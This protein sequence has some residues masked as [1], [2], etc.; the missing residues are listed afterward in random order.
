MLSKIHAISIVHCSYFDFKDT[1]HYLLPRLKV[2][3]CCRSNQLFSRPKWFR[4]P[5]NNKFYGDSSNI[6]A[7][8]AWFHFYTFNS[9]TA[10]IVKPQKNS[11]SASSFYDSPYS[12]RDNGSFDRKTHLIALTYGFPTPLMNRVT[13][14]AMMIQDP[15][16]RHC[17]MNSPYVTVPV[18]A[19]PS[20]Q[21]Q[22]SSNQLVEV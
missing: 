13:F 11:N 8:S 1:H 2:G 18:L 9:D 14:T 20:L 19:L 5:S 4:M 3:S 15:D 12:E 6:T 7:K 16:L 10:S 22:K 17:A 21:H